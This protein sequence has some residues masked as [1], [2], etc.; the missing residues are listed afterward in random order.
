M[1]KNLAL[2][3]M[4]GV[5][6]ST[7]GKSL[8]KRL[9]M[10]FS[11]IDK[12]IENEFKMNVQTIFE[13]KGESFFRKL[14]EKITLRESKKRNTVISLGGGAFMNAKIR[15]A[16]LLNSKSFW[17]DLDL[18]LIKKRLIYSKKR[19]LL[20]NKNLSKILERI[21]NERKTTYAISNYRI[22]CDKLDRNLIIKKI[23]KLYA[24]N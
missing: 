18:A 14:E 21:Y 17:L 1:K 6:K 13:K 7:I 23:I 8:S 5:G 2:T 15:K 11:D 10:E 20:N 22:K 4:M 16:I 19:P 9:L 12:I 24:D 3:G